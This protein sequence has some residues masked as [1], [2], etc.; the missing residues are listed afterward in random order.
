MI[1]SPDKI[2]FSKLEGKIKTNIDI[3]IDPNKSLEIR[4]ISLENIGSTEEIYEFISEFE[5]VL[6]PKMQEYSH[7][8]FNKLFLH[9]EKDGNVFYITRKNRRSF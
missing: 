3:L 5:P 8:A 1:F 6:S 9:A 4:N 7:P 2:S